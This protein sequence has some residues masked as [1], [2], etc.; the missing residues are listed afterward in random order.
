M[1]LC[2]TRSVLVLA[3]VLAA[4]SLAGL[5]GAQEKAKGAVISLEKGGRDPDRVLP[6]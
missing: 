6:R 2:V 5:A 1:R 3:V 4:V